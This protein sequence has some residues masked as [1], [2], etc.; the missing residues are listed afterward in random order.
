[1]L[2]C[3]NAAKN[4]NDSVTCAEKALSA[5]AR[6]PTVGP[7]AIRTAKGVATTISATATRSMIWVIG[8]QFPDQGFYAPQHL[9]VLLPLRRNVHAVVEHLSGGRVDVHDLVVHDQRG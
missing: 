2:R 7:R 6:S 3:A 9:F 5:T 8:S 1:M 4:S